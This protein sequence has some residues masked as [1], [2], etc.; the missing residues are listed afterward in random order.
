[1]CSVFYVVLHVSHVAHVVHEYMLVASVA[2]ER[3]NA[4]VS[5]YADLRDRQVS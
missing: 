1:M 3:I 5:S 4:F 2:C